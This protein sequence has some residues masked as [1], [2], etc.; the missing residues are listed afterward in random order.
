MKLPPSK[1]PT[2][3]EYRP[4]LLRFSTNGGIHWT[5]LEQFDFN[6]HETEPRYVALHLPFKA[7]SNATRI[8][9]W[10]PTVDGT[11]A[12]DWAIDQVMQVM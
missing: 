2:E 3:T 1:K 8:Q 12:V 11:H 5:I 10:Q 6:P 4:V 9:W 7:Q